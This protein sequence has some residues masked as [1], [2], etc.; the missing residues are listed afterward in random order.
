MTVVFVTATGTEVG[1]T[2]V[3][4]GLIRALKARGRTVEPLKPVQSGYDPRE[5]DGSDRG[6]GGL[7]RPEEEHGRAPGG[8]LRASEFEIVLQRPA[9]FLAAGA[10]RQA[11]IGRTARQQRLRRR[12]Y[13]R[14][15]SLYQHFCF[16]KTCR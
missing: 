7:V 6:V 16:Q 11:D 13:R 2:F 1:K 4:R 3:S 15:L 8:G 10:R 12:A 9:L 5:A 14:S